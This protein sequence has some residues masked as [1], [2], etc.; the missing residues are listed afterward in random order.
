MIKTSIIATVGTSPPVV[1]EFMQYVE[2][3]LNKRVTDLTLLATLE[4]TV[5]A[6]VEL[7]RQAV[8]DRYPH[9]N[10]HVVNLPFEDISSDEK[11]L[12]FAKKAYETLKNERTKHRS[13]TIYL[14]VAGGRKDMC[15]SLSL[16]GQIFGVN[17]I[18][19]VIMSDVKAFNAALERIR[20]EMTD[21][22]QAKD[23]RAYYQEKKEIFYPIVFP[24]LR[25]Y[26]V[27]RLPLL[28][29]P[30][31][32]LEEILKLLSAKKTPLGK[33]ALSASLLNMLETSNFIRIAGGMVY[34]KD[35][36]YKLLKIFKE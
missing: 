18:Y 20:K 27:I 23:K 8:I 31:E 21:L 3:V 11:S 7:I 30:P 22:L 24:P 17:G 15:I 9:T 32:I 10:V 1:T 34:T 4:D 25:D 12:E 14:C 36:G 2:S 13:E 6:G 19:H 26:V 35:S 5:R 28:P 16:I 29:Y 33:V